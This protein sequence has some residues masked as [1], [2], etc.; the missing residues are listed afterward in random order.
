MFSGSTT[1]YNSREGLQIYLMGIN[2]KVKLLLSRYNIEKIYTKQ[3]E[4]S[5]IIYCKSLLSEPRQELLK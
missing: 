5:V 1:H 2:K 4:I 3:T